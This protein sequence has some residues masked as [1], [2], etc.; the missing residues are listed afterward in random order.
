[1]AYVVNAH[2]N[3][4]AW[5]DAACRVFLD[6]ATLAGRERNLLWL[7]FT[8]QPLRRL[9]EDWEGVAQ[10]MLAL[11]RV[12]AA[13]SVGEEWFLELIEE[14]RGVSPEFRAWCSRHDIAGSPRDA[15]VLNHPLVGQ[16]VLQA[17]PLQVAHASGSWMLVYTPV[18]QTETPA[19]LKRLLSP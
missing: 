7:L 4:V 17:N 5:N 12:S 11:F 6:F 19:R 9:Y 3:I 1:P 18:M 2:W 10:R 14:L 15:K 16:L 13:Q 8:Y